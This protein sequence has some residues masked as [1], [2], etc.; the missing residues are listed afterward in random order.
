M[1]IKQEFIRAIKNGN[2]TE[3]MK[4]VLRSDSILRATW[5]K[6]GTQVAE[7]VDE[8]HKEDTASIFY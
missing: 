6:D 2:R 7:I 5:E 8:I 3:L 1:E 4:A